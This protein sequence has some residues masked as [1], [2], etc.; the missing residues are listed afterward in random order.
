MKKLELVLAVIL[1]LA[2]LLAAIGRLFSSQLRNDMSDSLG[3]PVWFLIV[4]SVVEIVIAIDLFLPRFRIL[5]GV[6]AGLTMVGATVFNIF[7]EKA[8]DANPR[9]AI[10]MTIVLAIVGFV[11]AWMAAGRPSSPAGLIDKARAQLKGQ[12]GDLA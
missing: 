6:G 4:V 1:G 10:P 3:L 12:V 7:G 8:G 5:G 11:V 2:L 9:Q